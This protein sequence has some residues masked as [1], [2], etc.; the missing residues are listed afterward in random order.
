MKEKQVG[1]RVL[2]NLVNI[3]IFLVR[4][5]LLIVLGPR[6]LRFF[7]PVLVAWLLA[8]LANPPVQFLER[9]MHIR[10]KL[11]SAGIIAGTLFL[12]V[13]ACYNLIVWLLSET[14]N[15]IKSLP[16]YYQILVDGL[17]EIAQNLNGLAERLSPEMLEGIANLTEN[18]TDWLGRTISLLGSSTVEA[19]GS[20]AGNIPSLLISFIFV[21]LFAYFF[22]AERERVHALGNRLISQE[23][24]AQLAL[25]RAHL[26]HALGGYF[27][28]QFKIMGIVAFILASGLLLMGIDYGVLLALIIALLDFLPMLGTGTVLMPWAL[29]CALSGS[30]PR[31][32]GLLVLYAVTQLTRQ[33]IQPKLVGDSVGVDTLTTLTLMFIGY[34]L[35]GI[36]GL[37]LAIP[38]GLILLQLYDAG[39]FDHVI[40]N[41][42]ELAETVNE[43][44]SS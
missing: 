36:I 17:A 20:M 1:E 24:R 27:R 4:A 43:W 35:H 37:I 29:F 25:I 28:A 9:H 2:K 22:I 23:L 18:L 8:Q 42:K 16:V 39:A 32:A 10:R 38:A 12:I 21:L 44:R 19:A 15:F 41:V 5:L 13:F 3:G 26:I 34:R 14:G 30:L 11:G 40:K 31:A 7:L 6:L 33:V